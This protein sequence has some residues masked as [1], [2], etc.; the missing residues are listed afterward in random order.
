MF[1]LIKVNEKNKNVLKNLLEYY[2][3][4]FNILIE[5]DGE[6]HYQCITLNGK[7]DRDLAMKN[8]IERTNKKK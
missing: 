5:Y 4:D 6:F 8:L 7:I 1:K 3:Y 2:L